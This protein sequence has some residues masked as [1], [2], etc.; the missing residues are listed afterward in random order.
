MIMNIKMTGFYDVHAKVGI[1]GICSCA[2]LCT[3][4]HPWFTLRS[5]TAVPS[6]LYCTVEEGRCKISVDIDT[7][8]K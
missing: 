1:I 7:T 2:Q 5:S 8:Q 3:G 6:W 4:V